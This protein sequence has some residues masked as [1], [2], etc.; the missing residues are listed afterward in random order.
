VQQYE[1]L[2]QTS[3]THAAVTGSPRHA[4]ASI[5][6]PSVHGSWHAPPALPLE[7]PVEQSLG[8][9]LAVS[10][11]SHTPL[12]LQQP[13]VQSLGQFMHVSPCSQAPLPHTAAHE[14]SAEH[15]WQVSPPEQMPSPHVPPPVELDTVVFDPVVVVG[16]VEPVVT[17]VVADDF[18]DELAL[19]CVADTLEP[20]KP[21]PSP[22]SVLPVAHP[23]VAPNAVSMQAAH[24]AP[25]QP[26]RKFRVTTTTSHASDQLA[27]KGR[28]RT[29]AAL[30]AS[31]PST[32]ASISRA[33]LV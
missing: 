27:W 28:C 19:E 12:L 8:Q 10:P 22:R 4:V 11:A 1:S 30:Y 25:S 17:P 3:L 20:P 5:A 33:R 15:D 16:L 9:L 18:V 2:E 21:P 23:W 6:A 32:S 7:T 14:Q 31:S 13:V 26:P 29:G 24:A